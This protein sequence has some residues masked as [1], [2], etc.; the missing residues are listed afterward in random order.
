MNQVNRIL[1]AFAGAVAVVSCASTVQVGG[2]SSPS[3]AVD[4][5]VAVEE[6]TLRHL[7]FIRSIT[8]DETGSARVMARHHVHG[9]H[10]ALFD[11]T[12]QSGSVE[13]EKTEVSC[14]VIEI[15]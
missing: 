9:L 10:G 11:C 13:V 3:H 14:R 12:V 2:V 4:R 15:S 7:F 5:I 6:A 8:F 1:G